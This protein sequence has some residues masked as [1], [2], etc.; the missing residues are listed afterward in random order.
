MIDEM[1][2]AIVAIR[3]RNLRFEQA[4]L[5]F[6]S[7][8]GDAGMLKELDQRL[9]EEINLVLEERQAEGAIRKDATTAFLVVH[10]VR[11]AF[12]AT[13]LQKPELYDEP[14]ALKDGLRRAITALL[15]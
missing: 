15:S 5:H 6:F 2:T 13:T 8:V 3:K 12:L 10:L 4:L 1:L 7:R 11:S 14:T 9:I